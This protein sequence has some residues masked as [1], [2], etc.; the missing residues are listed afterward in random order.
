MF[1][2]VP[3]EVSF[4]SKSQRKTVGQPKIL[5]FKKE[6]NFLNV[7]HENKVEVVDNHNQREGVVVKTEKQKNYDIKTSQDSSNLEN[8][9]SLNSDEVPI[10]ATSQFGALSFDT[11][12]FRYSYYAGEVVK[13][14]AKQWEWVENYGYDQLRVLLYFKIRRDGSISD[15][16]VRKSSG[17]NEYDK[18]ALDT[19]RRAIPFPDL[20]EGYKDDVLGV[21]FEF[22]CKCKG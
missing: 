8:T 2:S 21:Y 12:D 19:I 22:K 7:K 13:K 16:S 4:C 18:Y 20:P 17:N 5:T 10:E 11:P 15:I 1:L 14:I 6:S 3:V 9:Q